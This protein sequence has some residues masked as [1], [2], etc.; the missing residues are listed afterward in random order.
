MSAAAG[1]ERRSAR[2]SVLQPRPKLAATDVSARGKGP[3]AA[4][5]DQ[6]VL[7]GR[8]RTPPRPPGSERD[9]RAAVVKGGR[10]DRTVGIPDEEKEVVPEEPGGGG[11]EELL[12]SQE[13]VEHVD[14]ALRQ[15]PDEERDDLGEGSHGG[16]KPEEGGQLGKEQA[17]VNG[18]SSSPSPPGECPEDK[19]PSMLEALERVATT[20]YNLQGRCA[21]LSQGT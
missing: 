3:V 13:R 12:L 11:D 20:V 17:V 14:K 5:E 9:S 4:T 18:S 16:E 1:N 6:I 2:N 19:L 8:R 10:E 7:G 21:R 15:G